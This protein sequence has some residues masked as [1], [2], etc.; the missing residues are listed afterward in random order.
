MRFYFLEQAEKQVSNT[1][2]RKSAYVFLLLSSE[3][4]KILNY[5]APLGKFTAIKDL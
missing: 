1:K 5:A 4:L 2:S 3:I